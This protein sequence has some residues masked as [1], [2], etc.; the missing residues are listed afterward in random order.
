MRS[1]V[2]RPFARELAWRAVDEGVCRDSSSSV[3]R[4]L[5]EA[6]LACR[7]KPKAKAKGAGREARPTRLDQQWQTDIK[8]IRAGPFLVGAGDSFP[9]RRDD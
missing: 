9:P 4:V 5:R 2:R 1:N 6:S 3:Y 7:W 8:H